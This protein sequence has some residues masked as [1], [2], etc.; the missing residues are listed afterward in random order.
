MIEDGIHHPLVAVHHIED[1]VRQSG[2]LEQFREHQRGRGIALTRLENET[3][4]GSD[5][6]RQHPQRDHG[7]EVEGSD[8]GDH[9]QRLAERPAVD[10]GADLLGELALEQV[11]NAGGKF[12]HFEAARHFSAGVVEHLAVLG[13]DDGGQPVGVFLQQIAEAKQHPRAAQRRQVRPFRERGRSGG[14]GLLQF[15]RRIQRDAAL[16]FAGGRIED[17]GKRFCLTANGLAANP[18]GNA[19]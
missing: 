1:A 10:A 12:H 14:D 19:L 13:G 9:A 7:G 16:D 5:G 11:R 2:F 6:D 3:V 8:A 4:T 17:V 15:R 18:V